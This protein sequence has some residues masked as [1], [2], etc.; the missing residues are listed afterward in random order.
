MFEGIETHD[1]RIF[2]TEEQLVVALEAARHSVASVREV[3]RLLPH[4]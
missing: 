3:H 1:F 2:V 4:E